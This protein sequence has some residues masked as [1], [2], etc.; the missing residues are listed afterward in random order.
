MQMS[1][2]LTG[3]NTAFFV[4]EDETAMSAYL[5][6][7]IDSI[8]NSNMKRYPFVSNTAPPKNIN[9]WLSLA[10]RL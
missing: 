5:T 4:K 9:T 6:I 1:K 2:K 8:I 10:I 3:F 7:G